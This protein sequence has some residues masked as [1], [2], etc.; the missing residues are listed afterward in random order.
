MVLEYVWRVDATIAS[1]VNAPIN[2]A[3]RIGNACPGSPAAAWMQRALSI[4]ARMAASVA[5][6][7]RHHEA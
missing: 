4:A 6:L 5:Q 2:A 7:S 1:R 3:H